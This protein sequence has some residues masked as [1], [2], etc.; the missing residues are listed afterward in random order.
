MKP[1]VQ[2]PV[3]SLDYTPHPKQSILHSVPVTQIFYGGA[4]GGGKSHSVRMDGLMLALENPGMQ[5]YLFRKTYPELEDNHIRPLRMMEIPPSVAT[6][7]ETRKQLECKN[8][9]ILRMCFAE[10]DADIL[11]HQGAEIHWL[12]V[13]EAA[14][15]SRFQLNYLRTRVRLGRWKPN[16]KY[17]KYFPRCLYSSNPGGPG[18]D[19]LKSTF[20]DPASPLQVF[21]DK[22][23]A[24]KVNPNGWTS[25][26]IPAKMADNPSIDMKT[27]E[28]AF[29]G[30]NPEHAKALRDGDWNAIVGAAFPNLRMDRN[31]VPKFPIPRHWTHF[32]AIDWGTA[33]PFSVG[34]YA[35]SDGIV[36]TRKSTGQTWAIPPGALVRF[37]EWYGWNGKADEG[38][39]LESN[40]VAVRIRQK[41]QEMGLPAMDFRVGDPQMWA[42]QD[43]P[44]PQKRMYDA[45]GGLF[46]LRQG[47]RDRRS[48]FTEVFARIG[49]EQFINE[50][51]QKTDCLP[52]FFVTDNCRHFWRTFPSLILDTTEPDKGP[53][54]RNQEDH[55][56]DE[57]AFACATHSIIST[58]QSRSDED[59]EAMLQA[60]GRKG[61]D[62]YQSR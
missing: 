5:G 54:T 38:V 21:Y 9:A 53:A 27:Y 13:D 62:P 19:F 16:P 46:V 37:E 39:R 31:M 25:I 18:H 58:P 61:Q 40:A 12:G 48:N 2:K 17:A 8:G 6:F 14:L 24:G 36:V 10:N 11:K 23:T 57:V 20:I 35:V 30:L 1:I 44:S 15:M 29:T 45:T 56:Y 28:G 59:Y 32:M 3:W 34:W 42:S 4:A 22:T 60:F 41:E 52:M 47:R 33:R 51:T 55:V 26:Y 7:S 50:E 49:G 43:G